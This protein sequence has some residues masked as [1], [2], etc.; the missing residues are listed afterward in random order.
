M[1]QAFGCRRLLL[2]AT[3]GSVA[4][5]AA[6]A[7]GAHGTTLR[8][9]VSAEGEEGTR[10][11]VEPL[12]SADGGSV[13]FS[14]LA[15]NLVPDDTNEVSDIFLRDL[16]TGGIERVSVADDGSQAEP[17]GTFLEHGSYYPAVSAGGRYVTFASVS[18]N[19]VPGD[20]QDEVLDVFLRDR[21]ASA[22]YKISIGWDGRAPDYDS[23]VSAVSADGRFVAFDSDA[24]TLV[25]D[26]TNE[27]TDVFVRDRLTNDIRRVSVSSSGDEG[28]AD[29]VLASMSAN[30]RHVVFQ[31]WAD[32][33]VADD[34]NG[35]PDV[36]V[37]DLVTAVT[38][39]LSVSA[40][41]DELRGISLAAGPA[42][43]SMSGRYAVF[44]TA[45]SRVVP[46]TS[47]GKAQVYLRD[48]DA[49][50]DGIFDEPDAIDTLRVTT[51]AQGAPQD[52]ET[53]TAAVSA[54]GAW[55]TFDSDA[56]DLIA[57]DLNA[58]TDVF[59]YEV[60]TGQISLASISSGGVQ[61]LGGIS[62]APSISADGSIVAFASRAGTL[63]PRDDNLTSDVFVHDFG[64]PASTCPGGGA[65]EGVPAGLL[66][67]Q[68]EPRAGPAGEPVHL[69]SCTLFG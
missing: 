40:T 55:V 69:L 3:I 43:I 51:T 39:R 68:V 14:S 34:T 8:V 30:G 9:S 63:V 52:G 26:E 12:L 22:T 17:R 66:H 58:T 45:A 6:G 19:L 2:L 31:S 21:I 38:T 10:E 67:E 60:A 4:L 20:T 23:Y 61:A 35:L 59:R 32:N 11:S 13:V 44:V 15:P 56:A 1:S 36:F 24:T 37:H 50:G 65:E 18:S 49:D 64:T 29:S 7:A 33:L 62:V 46:G 25:P 53:R 47:N 48:R 16:V 57:N 27:S 28:N 54:D 5:G 42:S 41:G